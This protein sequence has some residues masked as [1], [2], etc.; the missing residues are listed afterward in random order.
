MGMTAGNLISV[1]GLFSVTKNM[2]N[3]I[4]VFSLLGG[5]AI[6]CALPAYCFITE[7]FVKNEKEEKKM[8]K[9]SFFGQVK[10][11]L[12]QT[13]KACKQDPALGIGLFCLFISRN[14]SM[15]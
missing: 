4:A 1:A 10:S 11:L 2:H 9:K 13:Y 5:L 12:K 3:M 6:F 8:Q 15:L 7:P 14:G